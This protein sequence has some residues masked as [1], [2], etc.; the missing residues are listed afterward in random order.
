MFSCFLLRLLGYCCNAG[1]AIPE[2]AIQPGVQM[3]VSGEQDIK[4][5]PLLEG[6]QVARKCP[7][8]SNG[9]RWRGRRGVSLGRVVS[10]DIEDPDVILL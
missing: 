2:L 5:L 6:H 3:P 10:P 7:A 4:L 1:K 9:Q 8:M